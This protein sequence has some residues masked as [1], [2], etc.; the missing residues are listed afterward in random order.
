MEVEVVALVAEL[1]FV[2]MEV[3][4]MAVQVEMLETVVEVMV[5]EV[6]ELIVVVEIDM[7]I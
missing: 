6:L 1:L 2:V 4:V 7:V 3:E 5:T